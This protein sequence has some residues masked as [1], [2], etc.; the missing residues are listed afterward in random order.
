MS[1]NHSRRGAGDQADRALKQAFRPIV[2][3]LEGRVLLAGTTL[4]QP[5]WIEQGPGPLVGISSGSLIPLMRRSR[6]PASSVSIL[7]DA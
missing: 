6:R 7:R 5:D 3:Q 1:G 2:E 4:K